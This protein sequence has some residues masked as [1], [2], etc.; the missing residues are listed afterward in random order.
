MLRCPSASPGR[1]QPEQRIH[2]PPPRAAAL[3]SLVWCNGFLGP[4]RVG[5]V[6]LA[7]RVGTA[8]LG[9]LGGRAPSLGEPWA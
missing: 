8:W 7:V 4:V 2:L 6:G 5:R 3:W 9:G 1:P